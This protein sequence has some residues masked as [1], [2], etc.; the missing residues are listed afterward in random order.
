MARSM[1]LER[2]RNQSNVN[3]VREKRKNAKQPHK[4][5]KINA[6]FEKSATPSEIPRNLPTTS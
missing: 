3:I 2:F 1:R 6:D 4:E 5:N